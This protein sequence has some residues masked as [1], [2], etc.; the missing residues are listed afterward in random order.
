MISVIDNKD[1]ILTKLVDIIKNNPKISQKEVISSV[2]TIFDEVSEED[3]TL[4]LQLLNTLVQNKVIKRVNKGRKVTYSFNDFTND[5]EKSSNQN[6]V[7]KNDKKINTKQLKKEISQF[8]LDTLESGAVHKEQLLDITLGKFGIDEV[9]KLDT[10]TDSKF[11]LYKGIIGSTLSEFNKSKIVNITGVKNKQIVS[12]AKVKETKKE[13][14]TKIE[15]KEKN[16]KNKKEVVKVNSKNKDLN[17]VIESFDGEISNTLDQMKDEQL[18]IQKEFNEKQKENILRFVCKTKAAH[19]SS[20]S[21][22]IASHVICKL[23]GIDLNNASVQG[24]P[25]DGGID[26]VVTVK[27][28]TGFP[29]KRVAIQM[30]CYDRIDKGCTPTEIKTFLGAMTLLDFRKGFMITTGVFDKNA[31]KKNFTNEKGTSVHVAKYHELDFDFGN[32]ERMIICIDGKT[33]VNY[34]VEYRLGVIVS[35]EG[36]I[37]GIDRDYFDSLSEN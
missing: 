36:N 25:D 34:M 21:E 10:S 11:T 4:I 31:I 19:N 6:E 20:I 24:G 5:V 1:F 32:H 17:S 8:I 37:V 26:A 2:T 13:V 12:L 22:T 16:Q 7:E 15:T 14:K 33:L 27:D 23:Y 28:P 9:A 30:K 35:D 18:K 3:K 29:A